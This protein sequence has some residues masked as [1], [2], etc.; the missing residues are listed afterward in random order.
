MASQTLGEILCF[1]SV[2]TF[3]LMVMR[4]RICGAWPWGLHLQYITIRRT[5]SGE[6]WSTAPLSSLS[7]P[8]A[9]YGSK[10]D[11]NAVPGVEPVPGEPTLKRSL[12]R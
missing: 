7:P 12:A 5:E 4:D 10:D 2:F 11:K 6:V 8:R 3:L 9:E 1:L